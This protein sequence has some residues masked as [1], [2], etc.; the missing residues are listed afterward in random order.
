MGVAEIIG[1]NYGY[2]FKVEVTDV[3]GHVRPAK[4]G[5]LSA[6]GKEALDKG[7]I[8]DESNEE[9][10]SIKFIYDV[11]ARAQI[12]VSRVPGTDFWN[13]IIEWGRFY[14]QIASR[15]IVAEEKTT[16]TTAFDAAIDGIDGLPYLLGDPTRIHFVNITFNDGKKII[17]GQDPVEP[18]GKKYFEKVTKIFEENNE[19]WVTSFRLGLGKGGNRTI[20]GERWDPKSKDGPWK[21]SVAWEPFKKSLSSNFI[22]GE[23]GKNDNNIISQTNKTNSSN[24]NFAIKKLA[25]LGM[26]F[27]LARQIINGMELDE[28][29]TDHRLYC[30]EPE[31]TDDIA[32]GEKNQFA[33]VMN[34]YETASLL[35][36]R[37]YI[38]NFAIRLGK[39]KEIQERLDRCGKNRQSN[40]LKGLY[41]W[42]ARENC[43]TYWKQERQM[44]EK[45]LY[46][47]YDIGDE[48]IAD[49]PLLAIGSDGKLL[50]SYMSWAA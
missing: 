28:F 41:R 25:E 40:E 17:L 37:K 1:E 12:T 8:L 44:K 11:Q 24:L 33:N 39:E 46:G 38:L 16:V 22:V 48:D 7:G 10:Q 6:F 2:D 34:D 20:F 42:A 30:N 50:T 15:R 13:I 14:F 45:R 5:G 9:V 35:K 21:I 4:R 36:I 49:I 32:A 29:L 47:V 19:R 23:T 3:S 18:D 31:Q 26:N 27:N 43:L